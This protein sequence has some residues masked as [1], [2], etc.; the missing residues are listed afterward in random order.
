MT[1]KL[2]SIAISMIAIFVAGTAAFSINEVLSN[3]DVLVRNVP[4][5]MLAYQ[6]SSDEEL[7]K[8][9]KQFLQDS[10]LVEKA[11]SIVEKASSLVENTFENIHHENISENISTFDNS[12]QL[13]KYSHTDAVID[14]RYSIASYC[15][16][17]R[18][19]TTTLPTW[20]CDSCKKSGTPV[21]QVQIFYIPATGTSGFVG[22]VPSSNRVIVAFAGTDPKDIRHI[23]TDITF[24]FIDYD[25]CQGCQVHMGFINAYRAVRPTV[26]SMVNSLLSLYKMFSPKVAATGHS[27]GGALANHFALDLHNSIFSYEQVGPHMIMT[28]STNKDYD[29]D[30]AELASFMASASTSETTMQALAAPIPEQHIL[31]SSTSRVKNVKYNLAWPMYTFGSPRIGNDMFAKFLQSSLPSPNAIM[32]LTHNKDPVP[33]LPPMSKAFYHSSQEIF[34]EKN[35]TS[36]KECSVTTGEDGACS[37]KFLITISIEDHLNYAGVQ[38]DNEYMY[39]V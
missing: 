36:Y 22:Y 14:V 11:S 38:V 2:L 15:T 9:A 33:H 7:A 20:Q 32:R 27:L 23:I 1:R 18:N 24:T 6:P 34:Y 29:M 5:I 21:Q 25:G 13:F 16:R 37:N 12:N 26:L 3:A 31:L 30:I 28:S 4:D 39:C 17:Y 10:S 8:L 19:V 35:S